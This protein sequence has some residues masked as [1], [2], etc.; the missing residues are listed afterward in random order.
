MTDVPR[1]LQRPS[2]ATARRG[3]VAGVAAGTTAVAG[4]LTVASGVT[5]TLSPGWNL[6]TLPEGPLADI[7]DAAEECY[8]AVY[9]LDGSG[10]ARYAPDAPA[11]VNSMTWSSQDAFWLESTG[12]CSEVDI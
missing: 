1:S 6:I 2:N 5:L 4:D 12:L 7:L 9:R 11:Y 3:G 8:S 10:W